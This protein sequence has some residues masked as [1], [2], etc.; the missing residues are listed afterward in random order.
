M[1]NAHDFNSAFARQVE[2]NAAAKRKASQA[3]E[4]F[5]PGASDQGMPCEVSNLAIKGCGEDVSLAWAVLSDV[6]PNLGEV[7]QRLRAYNN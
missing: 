6:G 7:L 5:W 3:S 1:E 2:D 4:Q